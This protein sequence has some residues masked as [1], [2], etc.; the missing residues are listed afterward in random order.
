M[1]A[2]DPRENHPPRSI[3]IAMVEI[4]L[5]EAAEEAKGAFLRWCEEA[6]NRFPFLASQQLSEEEVCELEELVRT[7]TPLE[8]SAI[9][10]HIAQLHTGKK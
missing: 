5:G 1:H 6:E 10:I 4:G 8:E 9:E 7:G 3:I 2:I